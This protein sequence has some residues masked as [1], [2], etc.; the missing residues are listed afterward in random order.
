M[1]RGLTFAALSISLT[2]VT[3]CTGVR[4]GAV[5]TTDMGA[6]TSTSA[7]AVGTGAGAE[8]SVPLSTPPAPIASLAWSADLRPVSGPVLVD[9]VLALYTLSSTDRLMMTALDAET[10]EQ[11]WSRPASTSGIPVVRPL[12][13]QVIDGEVVYLQPTVRPDLPDDA[14]DV[15]SRDPRTGTSK[16]T[17]ST[18][19]VHV[20]QPHLCPGSETDVCTVLLDDDGNLTWPTVVTSSWEPV[21]WVP[22]GHQ[23][24]GHFVEPIGPLDLARAGGARIGRLVDDTLV[25]EVSTA[26]LVGPRA[27]TNTGWSFV[28]H[29]DDLLIGTVGL[30]D[31][32]D[33]ADLDL[34]ESA[35][36]A[37][38]AAT[39][40]PSW[41][42]RGMDLGCNSTLWAEGS[43]PLLA[44]RYKGGV[45]RWTDEGSALIDLDADLVRLDPRTGE[46]LWRADLPKGDVEGTF[47]PGVL[48]EEHAVVLDQVVDVR[49]GSARHRT[50]A[51]RV[52]F[53]DQAR[54]TVDR[55]GDH[56]REVV[57]EGLWRLPD[58]LDLTLGG[59]LPTWPLPPGVGLEMDDGSRVVAH[60]DG[61][62]RLASPTDGR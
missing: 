54:P 2:L 50:E 36:F 60:A 49:D 4:D 14:A 23:T 56:G 28:A 5:T 43:G 44:C 48:D 46:A 25:W 20:M 62:A 55:A 38:D 10:G 41:I 9:G 13:P 12:E 29:E 52:W 15:I 47:V 18:W 31:V 6:G 24:A 32:I 39:G 19:G 45:H 1:T 8:D 7:V 27:S 57:G 3:A 53:P 37:L 61:I 11:L 22:A 40:R 21:P 30:A 17:G 58:G 16:G 59:P 26:D 34:T 51:D 42:A 33:G 35:V